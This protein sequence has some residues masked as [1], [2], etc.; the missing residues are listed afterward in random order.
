MV[1][2]KLKAKVKGGMFQVPTMMFPKNNQISCK[3]GQDVTTM[4]SRAIR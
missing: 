3:A 2:A 1:A 4:R